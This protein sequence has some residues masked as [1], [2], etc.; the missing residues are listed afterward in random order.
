MPAAE[1]RECSASQP[2]RRLVHETIDRWLSRLPFL[3]RFYGAVT[4]VGTKDAP[5]PVSPAH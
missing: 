5:E 1:P 3:T 2:W 4:I